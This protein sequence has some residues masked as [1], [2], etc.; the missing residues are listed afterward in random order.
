M[1]EMLHHTAAV[2]RGARSALVV[3]DLPFMSYQISPEQALRN[4][5]RLMKTAG[6]GAVKLEGGCIREA[7]IRALTSN[8]IPVVGHIGLLPQSI[9]EL[10]AYRVQGRE[11]KQAER[12]LADAKSVEDAGGFAIVLEC[13]TSE[14]A[15]R[16]TQ[17]VGIPTIGIGSGPS[18]DGQV[19]VTY[20]IL[21]VYAGTLP[22]FVKRYAD[23]GSTI[24][25]AA[26]AFVR[27]VT[28]GDFPGKEH[29]F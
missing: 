8:G 11:P 1:R 29:S 9:R 14:L 19:L 21:G 18:C 15:E 4:A 13:V 17:S 6:A 24:S 3:A 2:V 10:G 26:R 23:V 16:I 12:L 28:G 22:R 25:A 20:D 7:T 5:G 27:E